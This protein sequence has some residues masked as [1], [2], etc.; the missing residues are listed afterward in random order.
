MMKTKLR[1]EKILLGILLVYMVT[2]IGVVTETSGKTVSETV[3]IQPISEYVVSF[4]MH[5]DDPL[6]ISIQV[7]SG[8][9]DLYIFDS[10]NWPVPIY[11]EDLYYDISSTFSTTFE[12]PWTDTWYLQFWNGDHS[13]SAQI[14]LTL[15]HVQEYLR[16]T[17]IHLSIG[18]A[19][20][21]I[22]IVVNFIGK[23]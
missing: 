21:G 13:N 10:E 15:E 11:Y 12:A 8:G 14:S 20:L 17:I 16:N 5:E 18:A 6:K 3:T 19:F 2:L 7:S 9:I 1:F 22:I 4:R 23:K